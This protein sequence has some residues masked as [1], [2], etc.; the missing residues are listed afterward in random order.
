MSEPVVDLYKVDFSYRKVPVLSQI[1]LQVLANDF[2][3]IIG[4]NGGG[5]STLVKL[6]AG[7][8][9][10]Q[11]GSVA[12]FGV[13]PKQAAVRVGYVPQESLQEALFPITVTDVVLMGLLHQRS[14]WRRFG[15]KQREAAQKALALVGIEYLANRLF[16]ELSGGERQRVLIARALASGPDLLVL[17]EP[18]SNIDFEG[19]RE[20]FELLKRLN[21]EKTVVVVS[22]NMAMV[23]GYA[24]R[25]AYVR[26]TLVMHTLNPAAKEHLSRQM[27]PHGGHYCEAEFW[28]N[29]GSQIP[30]SEGCVHG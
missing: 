14:I 9:K 21:A 22:H 15:A 11:S 19:Q 25:V 12:I 13:S 17:D 26:R 16:G 3:C 20:I 7:I 23:M 27:P 6:L 1:D 4:P 28:Q 5:K 10:P 2:L 29:L 30:C 8:L 18:T 24:K